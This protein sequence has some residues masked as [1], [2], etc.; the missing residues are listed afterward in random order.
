MHVRKGVVL[1]VETSKT[2]IKTADASTVV[3]YDDNLEL[4][5]IRSPSRVGI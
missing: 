5:R 3:I 1:S 4:R 2:E